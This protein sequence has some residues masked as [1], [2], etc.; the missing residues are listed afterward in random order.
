[1]RIV[2]DPT[3]WLPASLLIALMACAGRVPSTVRDSAPPSPPLGGDRD[4][5]AL[6]YATAFDVRYAIYRKDSTI[7]T[8]SG[9]LSQLQVAGLT[10][11]LRVVA[12]GGA[13]SALSV[14]LDSVA[15]NQGTPVP[16][17]ATAQLPGT[18]WKAHWGPRGHLDTL[19]ASRESQMVRQIGDYLWLLFPQLP[20][21]GARTGSSWADTTVRPVHIEAFSGQETIQSTYRADSAAVNT[22]GP[23]VKVTEEAFFTRQGRADRGGQ[24]LELSGLG[25][26][27][28]T[29]NISLTGLLIDGMGVDSTLM[30]ILVPGGPSVPARRFGWFRVRRLP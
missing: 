22:I 18:T 5:L 19:E 21:G 1:M 16:P 2:P 7:I 28:S 10:A 9:G 29:Y 24:Q 17:G 26:R 27:S 23:S 3:S 14:T 6:T 20:L 11:Y 30:T 25:F 4:D 8:G 15:V 13:R 12:T